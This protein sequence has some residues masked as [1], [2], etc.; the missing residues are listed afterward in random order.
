MTDR[1]T[2]LEQSEF[3]RFPDP[4]G[5]QSARI[6]I[7]GI[8]VELDGLPDDLAA[9]M[10]ARYAPYIGPATGTGA[11]LRLRLV[12][13]P[14]DY[15]V[16]PGFAQRKEDYRVLT[17][18]D[19]RIFR[20][21]SY[22]LAAWF[23]LDRRA[24]QVALAQG[25]LDP[26]PRAMENVLRSAVAWLAMDT[27][28]FLLHGASIVRGGAAYLFFGPS[29][30]GKSTLAATSRSGEVISDDLTLVLRR[31]EGLRASGG[32]FR[33]TY[34]AGAPVVG[35]FPVQGFYRLRK[36]PRTFVRPGDAACFADL[37]GNLPWIVDQLPRHPHLIDRVRDLVEGASFSYLHFRKDEDFWPAVEG[38]RPLAP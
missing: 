14:L 33:G 36:D 5:N 7:S 4:A 34:T 18:F 9:A 29:G 16:P 17:A 37:L 15:F 2:P 12:G 13:A 25:D 30:A 11:P 31:P 8:V 3:D 20:F 27:G 6:D 38:S 21:T 35:L 1:E 28:G 32:P 19:G 23:D 22:R 10:Q 26:G 24:G